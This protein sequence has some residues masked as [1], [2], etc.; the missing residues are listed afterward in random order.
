[1]AEWYLLYEGNKVGPM[2]ADNLMAYHPT[3]DMM[4]WTEGMANWQ[5]IYS[6]PELMAK[7][8][9]ASGIKNPTYAPGGYPPA[10]A[11]PASSGKDKMA[12]GILAILLGGLGVQYFYLGRIGAGFVTILLDI[13]TCGLWSILTIVQGVLMLTMTQQEFDRKYV[14]SDKFLPLF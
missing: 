1:M 12:C 14:Y 6:I 5:P 11:V 7:I 13:V 9:G 2:S 4:V 10:P 3:P 8:N